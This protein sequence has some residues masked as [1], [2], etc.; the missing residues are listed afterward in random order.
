V[1]VSEIWRRV[2]QDPSARGLSLDQF[3]RWLLAANRDGDLDLVRADLVGA[4]NR[5]QV[6]ESEISDRGATFHFVVDPEKAGQFF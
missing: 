6:A 2:Q 1:F 3:K 5:N 4:M